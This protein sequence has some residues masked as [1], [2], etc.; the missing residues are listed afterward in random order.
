[1]DGWMNSQEDTLLATVLHLRPNEVLLA[2]VIG[3]NETMLHRNLQL[4]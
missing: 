1:M 4:W 2:L 3:T